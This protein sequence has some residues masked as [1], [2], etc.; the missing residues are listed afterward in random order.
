MDMIRDRNR[1]SHTYNQAV[2]E[3]IVTHITTRFFPLF[4]T[5]REK[6]ESLKNGD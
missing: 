3:H 4:L 6:M 1:T 2:A 5:L